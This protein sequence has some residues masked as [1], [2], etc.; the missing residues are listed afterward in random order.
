VTAVTSFALE[1]TDPPP[2]TVTWFVTCEGALEA[3]FTVTA[4]DGYLAPAV[5]ASVRV[6]VL[7]EQFQPEPVI[8]T[9]VSPVGTASVTVTVPVVGPAVAALPTVSV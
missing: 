1:D 7:P 3:T 6:Q 8:E 4:I 9:S 2:E 5:S